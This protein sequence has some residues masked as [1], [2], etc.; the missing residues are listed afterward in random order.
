LFSSSFSAFYVGFTFPSA[1]FKPVS[2]GGASCFAVGTSA[3][4]LAEDGG[5]EGARA[6]VEVEDETGA[7]RA[8]REVGITVV[9]DVESL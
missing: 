7:T 9:V 2:A 3:D 6:V 1:G 5:F 8:K 4:A